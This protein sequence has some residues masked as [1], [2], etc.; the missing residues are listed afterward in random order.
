ML[1]GLFTETKKSEENRIRFYC[2]RTA[3]GQLEYEI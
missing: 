3:S 1:H 2:S